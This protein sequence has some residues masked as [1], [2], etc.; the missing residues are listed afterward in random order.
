MNTG[1]K[2]L[3]GAATIAA[4][5]IGGL[6]LAK[7]GPTEGHRPGLLREKF[8]ALSLT[9][10]Q[11]ATLKQTLQKHQPTMKPLVDKMV[12][13]RQALQDLIHA[14]KLDESAIR[15]QAAKVA[16]V[17][18]DL[19]VERAKIAQELRPVLT[20]EQIKKLQEMRSEFRGRL[21]GARERIGK[22]LAGG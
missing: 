18:V 16:A 8:A 11:K 5:T 17:E 20:A 9:D 13:E 14:E 15:A 21:D 3:M 6:A 12:T 19:A 1:T 7:D 2:W 10:A 22:R 4:L